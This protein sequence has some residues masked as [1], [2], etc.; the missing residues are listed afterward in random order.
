MRAGHG[1]LKTVPTDV[2][3]G[4]KACPNASNSYHTCTAWCAER[5]GVAVSATAEP[6]SAPV[7]AVLGALDSASVDVLDMFD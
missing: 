1:L 5:W 2:T 3:S 6:P 7:K 4:D